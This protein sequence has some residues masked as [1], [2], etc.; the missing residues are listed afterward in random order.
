MHDP[1]L[2]QGHFCSVHRMDLARENGR[3]RVGEVRDGVDTGA[4]VAAVVAFIAAQPGGSDRL[5]AIHVPDES[6]RCQGCTFGGTGI[7]HA[8]W[9]CALHSWAAEAAAYASKASFVTSA[10]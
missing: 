4:S 9:P 10:G 1:W 5:L 7:P 8:P 2:G 3:G 6:G